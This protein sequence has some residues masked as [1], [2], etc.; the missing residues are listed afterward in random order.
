MDNKKLIV[1]DEYQNVHSCKAV[2]GDEDSNFLIDEI[3]EGINMS[4]EG[5]NLQDGQNYGQELHEC[6]TTANGKMNQFDMIFYYYI[7]YFNM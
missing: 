7:I 5:D 3:C 6:T 2:T 1:S 4:M